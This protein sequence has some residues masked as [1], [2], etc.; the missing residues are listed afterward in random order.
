MDAL[1]IEVIK[2]IKITK[3]VGAIII[4]ESKYLIVKKSEKYGGHWDFPKGAIKKDET[5]EIE[6]L[7]R[8]MKEETNLEIELIPNFYE[9]IHYNYSDE[10]YDYDKTVGYYL[11]KPLTTTAHPNDEEIK[12]CKWVTEKELKEKIKFKDSIKVFEEAKKFI[13]TNYTKRNNSEGGI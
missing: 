11:A 2:K 13:A 12:E 4:Y 1:N 7:C 6:A 9:E 8:E 3:S 5:D 10:Y